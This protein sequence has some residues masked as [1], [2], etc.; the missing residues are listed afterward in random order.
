M[1]LT[2]IQKPPNLRKPII[3]DQS[4]NRPR[5]VCFRAEGRMKIDLKISNY[6]HY[7]QAM[8]PCSLMW[9]GVGGCCTSCSGQ[10]T[11]E[12]WCRQ[13][14]GPGTTSHWPGLWRTLAAVTGT[15]D[16]LVSG[17]SYRHFSPRFSVSNKLQPP[18]ACL[19]IFAQQSSTLGLLSVLWQSW[20]A[21]K[22]SSL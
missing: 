16:R 14:C 20:G 22:F 10:G 11:T 4:K 1:C 12:D 8:S 18:F 9:P 6:T 3:V 19:I 15:G 21:A 17:S 13:C 2:N 7:C 5:K